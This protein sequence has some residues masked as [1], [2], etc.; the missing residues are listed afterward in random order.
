MAKVK[1][2]CEKVGVIIDYIAVGETNMNTTLDELASQIREREQAR[3][4]R[5]TNLQKVAQFEQEQ[6]LKSTQ[7]L[8]EQRKK[9]IE[10][11]TKLERAKIDAERM[12]ANMEAE[13]TA[14]EESAKALR[15]GAKKRAEA[16]LTTGK[17]EANVIMAENEA[18]VAA[19]QT[20]LAGFGTAEAFA[21]YHVLTNVTPVLSEIFASDTSDFARL[22][23]N[24]LHSRPPSVAG[25]PTTSPATTDTSVTQP[26]TSDKSVAQPETAPTESS[27]AQPEESSGPT[28]AE[29]ST[30]VIP[31]GGRP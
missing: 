12:L 20:A 22:F 9:V 23:S 3:I 10:A 7:A 5:T 1:P 2:E 16:T 31:P 21:D 26:T 14:K 19:L 17:A 8:S 11:N 15:D 4:A 13:Q 27:V 28:D 18:E 24:Y 25:Q 29:N 30:E 6:E